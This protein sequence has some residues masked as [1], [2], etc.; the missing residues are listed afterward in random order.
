[1]LRDPLVDISRIKSYMQ[2]LKSRKQTLQS[3]APNPKSQSQYLTP[4]LKSF[5]PIW[6]QILNLQISVYS[7]KKL[8]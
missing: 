8:H 5:M 2:Y 4:D 3:Q 1:M 6:N 7:V